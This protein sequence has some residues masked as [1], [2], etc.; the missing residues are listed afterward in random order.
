M[1]AA[2]G[3]LRAAL[4]RD[5][6]GMMRWWIY[7]RERFPLAAHGPLIAAFSFCA[8]SLSVM[9]RGGREFSW[10]AIGVAFVTCLLLFLQLRIA[11]EFKDF[12]EDSRYRPYRAVPRGLVSLRE[13]AWIFAAAAVVQLVLAL[14]LAPPLVILLGFAWLYLALMAR[15]FGAGEF[16]RSRPLLYLV[17]HMF[18]MPIVD[19]YA[20]GTDWLV[21]GQG[22]PHAL[23]WFLAASFFNGMSLDIGRKIRSPLDEEPG[24][25]TYSSLW[26]RPRAL[27]AW[28]AMLLG[29]M[30]CALGAAYP[31]DIARELA[32]VYGT[33][34]MICV[35]AAI[36]M[37]HRAP[38][39]SGRRIEL[40]TFVW[41][42]TLYLGLGAAPLI[43][44]SVG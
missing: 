9:L 32:V 24:V 20:T 25:N 1:S 40:L 27:A 37:R 31:L 33:L 7:Q 19:L 12:D 8:V 3:E 2:P 41:T 6:V 26:G 36:A 22:M 39:G 38:P 43:S 17:S 18:I 14:W 29:S 44:R 16:L 30:L 35:I 21:A 28:L 34:L 23:T 13:L 42:L 5:P 4:P 15:E 11:D 10:A